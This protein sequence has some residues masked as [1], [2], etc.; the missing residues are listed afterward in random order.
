MINWWEQFLT[1]DFQTYACL[2]CMHVLWLYSGNDACS[3]TCA[4]VYRR[5]R[6]QVCSTK[7]RLQRQ[8]VLFIADQC[9]HH[10]IQHI[11]IY[12]YPYIYIYHERCLLIKFHVNTQWSP[13]SKPKITHQ[14]L[15]TNASNLILKHPILNYRIKTQSKTSK[16]HSRG[17][18]VIWNPI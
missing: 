16:Q 13:S 8:V 4:D 15:K 5:V 9:V 2:A 14:I 10:G 3:H 7:L 12:T 18:Q 11:Y 17:A 1:K 6:T